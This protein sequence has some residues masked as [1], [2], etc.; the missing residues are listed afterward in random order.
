MISD[1]KFEPRPD[2]KTASRAGRLRGKV[3]RELYTARREAGETALPS[4]KIDLLSYLLMRSG[5]SGLAELLIGP[6][7]AFSGRCNGQL[8]RSLALLVRKQRKKR[9]VLRVVGNEALK[10]S[11][12]NPSYKPYLSTAGRAGG[13]KSVACSAFGCRQA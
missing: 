8:L 10:T 11:S 6:L 5:S 3:M 7:C 1:C 12:T 9:E 4:P 13:S 2:A